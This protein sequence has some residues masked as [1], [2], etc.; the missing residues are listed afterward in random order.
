MNIGDD[1]ESTHTQNNQTTRHDAKLLLLVLLNLLLPTKLLL[2]STAF[3]IRDFC[4]CTICMGDFWVENY[5]IVLKSSDI[6][7]RSV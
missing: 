5:L 7:L 4:S 1:N 2:Y 3:N 6:Q